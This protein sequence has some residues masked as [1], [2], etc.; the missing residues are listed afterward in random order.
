MLEQEYKK[1]LSKEQY[2]SIE[3]YFDFTYERIQ[4]N[5]YYDSP[6]FDMIKNGFTV[7]VREIIGEH[8]FLQIKKSADS[9]INGVKVRN[10]FEREIFDLP[11]EISIS[12]VEKL[13]NEKFKIGFSKL[14][15]IGSLITKRKILKI[16]N[17]EISLDKNDYLGKIDYELE[18]EFNGSHFEAFQILKE[19]G[20]EDEETAMGKNK[21][22][23]KEKLKNL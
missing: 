9:K 21:R 10:E 12:N 20:L 1:M 3:S 16:Q 4:I 8:L 5:H 13:I 14:E 19:L 17:C 6:N 2:D 11:K 18:I 23:L 15:N 22:F 7:R